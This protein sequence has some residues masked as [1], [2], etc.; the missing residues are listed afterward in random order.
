MTRYEIAIGPIK[1]SCEFC[2]LP[3]V[4]L[5][6]KNTQYAEDDR[7]WAYACDDCINIDNKY[8]QEQWDEYYSGRI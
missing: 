4:N 8:W 5:K 7:N 3:N 1:H 6:R 2:G